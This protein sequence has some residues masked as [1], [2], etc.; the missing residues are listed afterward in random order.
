MQNDFNNEEHQKELIDWCQ[1]SLEAHG[2]M[3]NVVCID[4]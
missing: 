1:R 4:V 3:T 2:S